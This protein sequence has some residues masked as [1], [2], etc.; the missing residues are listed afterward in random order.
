MTNITITMLM[1]LR[2]MNQKEKKWKWDSKKNWITSTKIGQTTLLNNIPLK[3]PFNFSPT[4]VIKD[5]LKCLF[6]NERSSKSQK[7][8]GFSFGESIFMIG[9]TNW[10]RPRLTQLGWWPTEKNCDFVEDLLGKPSSN[11]HDKFILFE[12]N[13]LSIHAPTDLLWKSWT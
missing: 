4:P 6:L 2:K 5:Y 9:T 1:N 8:L 12:I 10:G 3:F 11:L 7:D 13:H